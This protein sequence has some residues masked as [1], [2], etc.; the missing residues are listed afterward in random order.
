MI[1]LK[2]LISQALVFLLAFT[3]DVR[4]RAE[5]NE[6][7]SEKGA[8]SEKHEESSAKVDEKA[9]AE[10]AAE[11]AEEKRKRLAAESKVL[12]L[13]ISKKVTTEPKGC[14]AMIEREKFSC[15]IRTESN[16]QFALEVANVHLTLDQDAA[17][18]I[19]KVVEKEF[20]T[21]VDKEKPNEMKESLKVR[22]VRGILH[23]S[24]KEK[25]TLLSEFGNARTEGGEVWLQKSKDKLKVFATENP[26]ELFPRGATEVIIVEPGF[27]NYLT[28]V[29]QSGRSENGIPVVINYRD[30]IARMARTYQGRQDEFAKRVDEFREIWLPASRRA[31]EIH[32][33]LFTKR[34]AKVEEERQK[35]EEQRRQQEND[36]RHFRDLF[37]KKTLENFD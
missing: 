34:M 12:Q 19:E 22:L 28:R 15:A 4:I 7:R 11:K 6:G 5:A 16:E 2:R 18:I 1:D 37:R 29:S 13:P 20:E 30:H 26:V 27:E 14:L 31:A 36:K 25:V 3:L 32:Q 21:E 10:K 24:S 9:A 23:V 33:E 17:V 8:E 35:E